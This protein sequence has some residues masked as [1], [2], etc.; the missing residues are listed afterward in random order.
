MTPPP[1]IFDLDGVITDTAEY[2]YQAWQRLA[3]EEGLPFDRE[4]NEACRG[5]SRRESLRVVLGGRPATEEQMQTMM[6]RKQRYY[7][8]SLDQIGPDDLLPGVAGL[9]DALDAA[10]I[11]YALASASKNARPVCERLGIAHRLAA[12]ADG[13][14]V[15]R[16]K[17]YP[18]LLYTSPSPRD[19]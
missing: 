17:P 12:L 2:H 11:P 13:Y 10:G 15:E 6:A 19:S 7:E 18:C 5:I 8:E 1:L 4:A 14:S 3:D 16:Q 9:L